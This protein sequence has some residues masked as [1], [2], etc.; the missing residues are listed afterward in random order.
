MLLFIGSISS[1]GLLGAVPLL[2]IILLGA[3]LY[4]IINRSMLSTKEHSESVN[5]IGIRQY[6][7]C[8]L[9]IIFI[10]IFGVLPFILL[11]LVNM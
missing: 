2:A 3:Y 6:A 11:N 7:G 5:F 10:F 1:F 9:L 8:L 4:F